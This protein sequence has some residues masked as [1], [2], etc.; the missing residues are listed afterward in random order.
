MAPMN[1]DRV[2]LSFRLGRGHKGYRWRYG[3]QS[4]RPE[5]FS[6]ERVRSSGKVIWTNS[7]SRASEIGSHSLA[8]LE[9]AWVTDPA[10]SMAIKQSPARRQSSTESSLLGF[11]M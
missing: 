3:P 6:H 10:A 9:R 11:L 8:L 2:G 5:S 4:Q 7:K 1:L